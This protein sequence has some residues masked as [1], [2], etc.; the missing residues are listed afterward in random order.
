MRINR[1]F[2]MGIPFFPYENKSVC[3]VKEGTVPVPLT[4][5]ALKSD[6]DA[7]PVNEL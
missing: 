1:G 7:L 6:D 3:Q 2:F 4:A 5:P